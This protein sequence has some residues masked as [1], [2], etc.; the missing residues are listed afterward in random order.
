MSLACWNFSPGSSQLNPP[1]SPSPTQTKQ[2][3]LRASVQRGAV[4]ADGQ[5]ST[6]PPTP[7]P[8][9]G[10]ASVSRSSGSKASQ[11]RPRTGACTLILVSFRILLF[12][13]QG[14][15]R[16]CSRRRRGCFIEHF[17]ERNKSVLS[18]MPLRWTCF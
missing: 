8:G 13:L 7:G 4:P 10:A 3:C 12:P 1:L 5:P 2:K 17:E 14:P 18:V 6:T 11:G 16:T 15:W 9:G